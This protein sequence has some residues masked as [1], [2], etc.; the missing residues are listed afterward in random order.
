MA[1]VDPGAVYD[2]FATVTRGVNSGMPPDLLPRDQFAYGI[3]ATF[4]GF[5]PRNRPGWTKRTLIFPDVDTQTNFEA[6]IFQGAAAFQRRKQLIVSTGGR[7]FNIRVDKW[8]VTDITTTVANANNRYR[9]WFAEAEDFMIVQDGQSSP[10]IYDGAST[11]RSDTFGINGNREV[12]VGTAMSYAIGRLWVALPDGRGFVAGDIVGGPSGTLNYN[13]RDAVLTFTE[14]DVVNEGGAFAVPFNAGEITAMLPVAQIDTSTGQGPLQVFTT[15]AV[16]SVNAPSDRTEWKNLIY[17]IQ[18]FSLIK[19]G[20]LSDRSTVSVNGDAWMRSID[21]ARSFV[22]ARRDFGTWVNTPMSQEVNRALDGDDESLLSFSSACLFDNRLLMTVK[23]YRSFDHGVAHRGLVALDFAPASFLQ[24]RLSP[25]WEGV[26]TG[27]NILQIVGGT[28]EGIERCFLFALSDSLTVELWEIT[29]NDSDDFDGAD[30]VPIQWTVEA[31]AYGFPNAQE[32]GA[33]DVIKL[34]GGQLWVDEIKGTVSFTAEYR[35]DED[36]C[37]HSWHTWSVCAKDETCGSGNCVTPLNLKA[38]YR[39]P[40]NL[41]T[42][43]STCDSATGKPNNIGQQFQPRLKITGS[44]RL[45]QLRMIARQ[46][47]EDVADVCA[48][49]EETCAQVTC[50]CE[51]DFAYSIE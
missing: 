49:S 48:S 8:D 30:Y 28:F 11:R 10:W 6:A 43:D 13:F 31:P 25:A 9:A 12:P 44:C 16:F 37:W 41:P 27:L 42:P 26:W 38:Q 1:R 21:G 17:P 23:P 19:N 14:N 34:Y 5:Y 22:V 32:V 35:A 2:G 4:R 45:K 50:A 46:E 15:S 47:Q 51:N 7:L 3:N 20:S 24:N 40:F 18:T 39:K 36:P 33:V 29:K